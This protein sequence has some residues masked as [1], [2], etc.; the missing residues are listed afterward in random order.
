M[1]SNVAL[2][3]LKYLL[4]VSA[5]TLVTGEASSVPSSVW[6]HLSL[7]LLP[8]K[9]WSLS[10]FS[11]LFLDIVRL[12]GLKCISSNELEA[13]YSN[14]F[15]VE[16]C[17]QQ[18]TYCQLSA[19]TSYAF[20]FSTEADQDR[21]CTFWSTWMY[22]GWVLLTSARLSAKEVGYHC[23]LR[24]K[25]GTLNYELLVIN[26]YQLLGLDLLL[27]HVLADSTVRWSPRVLADAAVCSTA[28][29]LWQLLW[30]GLGEI[31]PS[32]GKER[33]KQMLHSVSSMW[34]RHPARFHCLLLHLHVDLSKGR[35]I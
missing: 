14:C 4:E 15:L 29:L 6:E 27:V 32:I 16:C 5:L 18:F 33:V 10:P 34:S 2:I 28:A 13:V 26:C 23:T 12:L 19:H 24:N 30:S 17:S 8:P 22:I 21:W 1:C 3:S 35:T 7:G 31:L 9:I 25:V 20:S 11:E